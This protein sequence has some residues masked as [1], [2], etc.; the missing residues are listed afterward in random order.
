M[1]FAEKRAKVQKELNDIEESYRKEMDDEDFDMESVVKQEADTI[2]VKEEIVTPLKQNSNNPSKTKRSSI[3]K[4]A[5]GSCKNKNFCLKVENSIFI[6]NL[7]QKSILVKLKFLFKKIS[8]DN[9]FVYC[10]FV[11]FQK[12]IFFSNLISKNDIL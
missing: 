3:E 10:C 6:R 2:T 5:F 11:K 7:K 4:V 9:K 8:F 12:R 1:I